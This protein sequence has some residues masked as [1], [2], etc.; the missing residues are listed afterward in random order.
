MTRMLGLR[1]PRTVLITAP[2]QGVLGFGGPD[3]TPRTNE[4]WAPD[5][6]KHV[7]DEFRALEQCREFVQFLK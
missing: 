7:P 1:V 2:D 5:D 3:G 4:C 6:L